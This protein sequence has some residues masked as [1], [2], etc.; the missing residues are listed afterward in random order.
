MKQPSFEIFLDR[1]D[2]TSRTDQLA[3][4]RTVAEAGPAAV[5]ELA[6]RVRRVSCPAGLKQLTLE[7]AYYYPWEDWLP[8]L[9]RLLRHEND[10][11]RFESG[12]RALGR[13]GTPAAIGILKEL[14][15]GRATPGFREAVEV[16]LGE[17][18]P[19]EAFQHHFSRLLQ[20]S[21]QPADANEGAHQLESLL[22]P[23]SLEALKE[24]VNHPD[25]LVFRHALRLVG[26]VPSEA[27][28]DFLL[29]YLQETHLDALEDREARALL[30]AFRNLP[31][32][33]VQAQALQALAARWGER[34]PEA[35]ADL[36]SGQAD[37]IRAGAAALR[38]DH[39]G[40]RD[41][42]L[43]DALLAATEEKPTHLARFLGQAGDAAQHRTRRLDF[44]ID[45]AA[46]GLT[47]LASQGFIE[48]ARLLPGLAESLRQTTGH[49]G[50]AGALAQVVPPDAQDL[51]D[52]LLDAPDGA[53][54][55][56]AVELLGARKD[57]ALRPALLRAQR[58]AIADI[59][60]RSLW[61]LGQLPDPAGT[62]RAFLTDPDP[63]QVQVGL[64]F[65]A[66]HR[67][68]ELVPD[69]LGLVE[70]ES[71]EAVLVAALEALGAIGAPEAAD[72]LL[73]L[74]HSGQAPR[75]QIALAE[76]LRDLGS[77]EGALG[78]CAK[79]RELN[80]PVLHAVAVEA[81][82]RIHGDPERPLSAPATAALIR[83]VQGG[84][85]DRNP[86][87]LRR[88]MADA[89]LTIH[90]EDPDLWTELSDLFQGALAEKRPPG[91]VS[92]DDL[93]R[94][95]AC[96]RSLALLATL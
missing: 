5:E 46:Q 38:E 96:A 2:P 20:G 26:L 32:A 94:L 85:S 24:A 74:L 1:L 15:Q 82:A 78:L 71:R 68:Q 73:G 91:E 47:A 55:A 90:A 89:L 72:P 51:L 42:F 17:S 14:A 59:A 25:L 50:V 21:A 84:W 57:P 69:L 93:A 65:A 29:D 37:R 19:A 36:A 12:V 54:R 66:M 86:W 75:I 43:L 6:G 83:A 18:D 64:R 52:L 31:R 40:I 35:A 44:A 22:T 92:P 67:L 76:A 9:D 88:R 8:V 4:F 48:A 33:E 27:A 16:V 30:A 87:P 79:A 10:L 39:P 7:F 81:L 34:R 62:A 56:A 41:A 11:A 61:H 95:Q 28:A 70:A 3:F 63:E 49:A 80:V 13:M 77:A 23:D 45:A 60:D 53:L 58:D